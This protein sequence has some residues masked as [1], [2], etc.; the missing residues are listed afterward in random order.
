M[1]DV[2]T[3]V[4]FF[5]MCVCTFGN[6]VLII[7]KFLKQQY[8]DVSKYKSIVDPAVGNEVID[9]FFT[10]YM[11]AL[12]QFNTVNYASNDGRFLIWIYFLATTFITNIM[13][14]NMLIAIMQTTY[15]RVRANEKIQTLMIQTK[16][17]TKNLFLLGKRQ[18]F[19][20]SRYLYIA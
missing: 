15:D 4:L 18:P 9:S 12:G 1:W 11:S 5:L 16:I 7:D 6:A 14:F 2:K 10:E 8:G 17:Q 19:G 20:S 13:I 3:F